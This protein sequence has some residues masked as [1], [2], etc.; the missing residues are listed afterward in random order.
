MKYLVVGDIHAQIGN[1]EDTETIL[2]ELVEII[3]D[4]KVDIVVF[5][6]DLYHTHSVV[7]QEVVNL[8]KKYM[9]QIYGQI[10]FKKPYVL[11][12]N[13]DLVGPTNT[14]MNAVSLTLGDD[15]FV[16]DKTFS[17]GGDIVFVPFMPDNEAF[18]AEC[19]KYPG[20]ITLF[21]HQT[22]DSAQYEN[23]FY[24]PGG[25]DQKKIPQKYVIAGHIHK[26]QSVGKVF[27]VGTP[28]A[29]TASDCNEDKGVHILDYNEETQTLIVDHFISFNNMVKAYYKMD[30]TEGEIDK[31]LA[32][33]AEPKRFKP[34]DD[35]TLSVHGSRE[36][37]KDMQAQ[38]ETV[39]CVAKL[40]VALDI[41]QNEQKQLSIESAGMTVED[42][43]KKYVFEIANVDSNLKDGVWK[44]IQNAMM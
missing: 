28:R 4:F 14:S 10:Q 13:H 37:C 41:K 39:G 8:F 34:E 30:I 43:L 35:V 22:F 3:R 42:A 19:N 7:R 40:R 23:G 44:T 21:C 17:P 26:K 20:A 6:G 31:V 25:V 5:L 27:Y 38:I 36:F 2:K 29:L 1:L 32:K 24:A 16:I 9:K 15:V 11:V 33:L 18:I 12:G